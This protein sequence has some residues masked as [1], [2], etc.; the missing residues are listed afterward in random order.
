MRKIDKNIQRL[1]KQ[2]PPDF[3]KYLRKTPMG[4]KYPE[5]TEDEPQ[6]T[7]KLIDEITDKTKKVTLRSVSNHHIV[8]EAEGYGD[9]TS[10]DGHGSPAIIEFYDGKLRIIA[11]SDINSEEPT[12]TIDLSDAKESRRNKET[13]AM[14]QKL[15]VQLARLRDDAADTAFEQYDFTKEGVTIADHDG[16]ET[17]GTNRLAKRFYY[18]HIDS[19]GAEEGGDSHLGCFIVEFKPKTAK[20]I[21]AHANI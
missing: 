1:V 7:V 3:V 2:L 17:D 18:R 4:K 15:G 10:K 16:W 14:V 21:D 6:M 8:I 5:L 13:P 9:C 20:V 12:H 19:D 11:W